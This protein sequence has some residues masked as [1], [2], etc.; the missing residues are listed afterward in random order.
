MLVRGY[1]YSVTCLNRTITPVTPL[2]TSL[3]KEMAR[4]ERNLQAS[5]RVAD[6]F[7]NHRLV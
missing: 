2:S 7:W 1:R 4:L 6:G 3:T 5:A